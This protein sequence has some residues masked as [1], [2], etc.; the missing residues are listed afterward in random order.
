MITTKK[1]RNI[2]PFVIAKT[3][4]QTVMMVS[5]CCHR[6]RRRRRSHRFQL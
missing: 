1:E 5:G 3:R 2:L 4:T 6:R